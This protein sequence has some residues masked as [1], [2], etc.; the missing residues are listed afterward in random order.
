MPRRGVLTWWRDRRFVA[1]HKR[2]VAKFPSDVRAAH[3]HCSNHRAEILASRR[4]GC[5]YCGAIFSPSEIRDWIEPFGEEGKTASVGSIAFSA[6]GL[7]SLFTP[8]F[9]RG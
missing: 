2:L 6:N 7:A 5:F 1:K 3:D 4:C 8:E 9:W